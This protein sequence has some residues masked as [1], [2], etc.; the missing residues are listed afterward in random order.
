MF[1]AAIFISPVRD[2]G[3]EVVQHFASFV[4]LTP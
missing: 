2:E 3:G 4:D 1:W